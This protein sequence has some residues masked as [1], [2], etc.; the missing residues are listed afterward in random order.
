MFANGFSF[1]W[2]YAAKLAK[3]HAKARKYFMGFLHRTLFAVLDGT[4]SR[5]F[6][7]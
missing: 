1:V 5:I 4:D 3:I 2:E 7:L 6:R